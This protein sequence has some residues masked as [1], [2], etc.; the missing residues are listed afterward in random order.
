MK[1]CFALSPM[2]CDE[3]ECGGE[4]EPAEHAGVCNLVEAWKQL[5]VIVG[6]RVGCQRKP[7]YG[8]CNQHCE[9]P[10]GSNNSSRATDGSKLNLIA[11]FIE[12]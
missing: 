5:Y 3:V 8:G 7:E 10:L 9:Q 12:M 11:V 6:Q 1:V 4:I 2:P